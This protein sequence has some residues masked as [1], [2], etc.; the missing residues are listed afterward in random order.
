MER[1]W[2]PWRMPYLL[3]TQPAAGC[4]FCAK[5]AAGSENDRD[6]LIVYRGRRAAIFV[7]LYPYNNGHLMV[8]PYDHVPSTEELSPE[9]LLELMQLLNL[10]IATLR[11]VLKPH[12]FNVGINLGRSAGAGI[13]EHVHLHIVPRWDGD[14]NFL[15]VCAQ[16]RV[17]PE[18]LPDTYDRLAGALR[19][20]LSEQGQDT[21]M[22]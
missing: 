14:T 19:Q 10:S 3:N 11:R 1:L 13:Q 2:S 20:L 6:N 7:N 5:L 16:T 4:V 8:I 18:M 17:I 9:A 12:G 21:A 15:Q 22:P